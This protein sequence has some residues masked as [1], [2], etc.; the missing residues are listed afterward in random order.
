MAIHQHI[1]ERNVVK[2]DDSRTVTQVVDLGTF[3]SRQRADKMTRVVGEVMAEFAK[4]SNRFE[5]FHSAHEGLAVIRE[6][7]LELED[8]VFHGN[9]VARY[10]EAKQLA[11]MAI[12][13]MVDLY[14]HVPT[15]PSDEARQERENRKVR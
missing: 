8:E 12:R 9:P 3:I 15:S 6:E 14:E 13:F 5:N 1:G 4:A 7:Y 10:K 11:A 2:S